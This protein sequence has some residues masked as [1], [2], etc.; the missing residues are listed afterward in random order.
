MGGASNA[1]KIP[2]QLQDISCNNLKQGRDDAEINITI[3]WQKQRS[4]GR[5]REEIAAA[6]VI[7]NSLQ[8]RIS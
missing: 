2:E 3:G 1:Y 8:K 4:D 7:Q 6:A 5:S